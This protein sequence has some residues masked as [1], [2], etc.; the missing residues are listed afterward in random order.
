MLTYGEEVSARRGEPSKI[1]L[2]G[3]ADYE[4]WGPATGGPHGQETSDPA[5]SVQEEVRRH[6]A[7][8]DGIDRQAELLEDRQT[9]E[10]GVVGIAEY[11]PAGHRPSF[12]VIVVSPM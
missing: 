9:D 4:I 2:R 7:A 3:P 11:H 1:C 10:G 8:A 5:D 6:E 12:N